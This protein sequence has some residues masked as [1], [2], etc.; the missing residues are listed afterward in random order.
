MK[1]FFYSFL[2][3]VA[4][5]ALFSLAAMPLGMGLATDMAKA[6]VAAILVLAVIP[7]RTARLFFV[8][9]CAW[10]VV[11]Y[12]SWRFHS[13]PLDGGLAATA[14]AMLLLCAE[15]YGVAMLLLGL[16]VNAWPLERE[17]APLPKD[18]K[19][20]PTVDVY[21]PTYSESVSVVAP[22]LMAALEIDYPK[23]KLR[24][25]V[26]DDGYPRSK[27][28]KT[29]PET[30]HELAQRTED[31]KALCAKHGA[32]WLSREKNEHAKSGNM[33]SAMKYT[34][35][36][37]L[38][39][40]DADHVPTRDILKNTVGFFRD[41]KMAFVQTPHFFLNADPVEK[42]LGLLNRMPGENDMFYRVVQKGLDLWNTS[43]FCGSAAVLRRTAIEAVGGFSI[44]S[45]TE[46]ASTSI[47]MH[48][49]GWRSAYLGIPMVAGLQPETFAGFTVQRLRWAMGMMQI[50]IK[51]NPLV[52]RG[53]SMAQRLSYL[54]VILFWL[55][56]FARV[57]FFVAPFLSLFF[58]LTIYP[59]GTEFFYGYTVPYLVAV[60]MSFEKTFG[61]VRRILISELYET[62]QAFYTLPAL[63]STLLNP[64]APTFKVTPKGER[65]DQ[66]FVSEFNKPFYVF[67]VLTLI[68]LLW[69]IAR[70]VFEPESRAALA[71]SV[72]WLCFNFILL[73]GSLG[74]LV[75]KVQR[76]DRPRVDVNE[77][78]TLIGAFGEC[79]ATLV[80]VNESGALIKTHDGRK[81][82]DFS[83][84]LG[85][86][87][88]PTEQIANREPFLGRGEHAVKFIFPTPK[89]ERTAVMLGYGKS[90]RWMKIWVDR[91]SSVNFVLSAL[92]VMRIAIQNG[93]SHLSKL[94]SS[95]R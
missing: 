67:Y 23:D 84:L 95:V 93:A 17:P 40:L 86:V 94:L 15:C 30:A 28:P 81:I 61:K 88:M 35:G 8:T 7:G 82:R 54:S 74:V 43:F 21:I 77:K 6:C 12:I 76:R 85:N 41:K 27:N 70:M 56:P 2:A 91:E 32:T 60:I 4:F 46:D 33:N 31:L 73:S 39:I 38:L 37:L 89:H 53:L 65:L 20:Y 14:G 44:D 13:L 29:H 22:T 87:I 1:T 47:K 48:Q 64:N 83:L 66:E 24:V 51:Q 62:L 71:L 26:L 19:D 80:D 59:V 3:A 16:F 50:F 42:N 36:E 69:G 5:L 63:I 45:I 72:A 49:K 9:L 68:G 11:R 25:Y 52:V 55:F 79:E 78:V 10:V 58:N 90:S 75:E 34:K 57:A 92:G 18:P